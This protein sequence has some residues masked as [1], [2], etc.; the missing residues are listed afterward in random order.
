MLKTYTKCIETTVYIVVEYGVGVWG[1]VKESNTD[2]V[3]LQVMRTYMEVHKF[4]PNLAVTGD[5]G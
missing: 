5:M 1:G 2:L 3:Q 4:A